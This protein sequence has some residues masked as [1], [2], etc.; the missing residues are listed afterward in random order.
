MFIIVIQEY[1]GISYQISSEVNGI[2]EIIEVA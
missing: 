1:T 2:P